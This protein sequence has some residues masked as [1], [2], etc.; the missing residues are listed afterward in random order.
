MP[1]CPIAKSLKR[2]PSRPVRRTH[3]LY[4]LRP[5]L[6]MFTFSHDDSGKLKR[7]KL[8]KTGMPRSKC[9]AIVYQDGLVTLVVFC[10][11][12]EHHNMVTIYW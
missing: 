4:G 8:I 6:I 2:W 9:R 10:G 1:L 5:P 11:M 7:V 3:T 12:L